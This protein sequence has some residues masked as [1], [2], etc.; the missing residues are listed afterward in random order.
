M[1]LIDK[2]YYVKKYRPP[3]SRF[4]DTLK[5]T[6]PQNINYINTQIKPK[7]EKYTKK[8]SGILCF[9]QKNFQ[10]EV[11]LIKKRFTYEFLDFLLGKY[12]LSNDN[13]LLKLFN[14]MTAQEKLY[15][16]TLDFDTMWYNIWMGRKQ[17]VFKRD[18]RYSQKEMKKYWCNKSRFER[19]F[20]NE[21]STKRIKTLINNSDTKGYL[22]GIPKGRINDKESNL[23]AAIREFEEETNVFKRNYKLLGSYIKDRV[24]VDTTIYDSCYFLAV[25]TKWF[26]PKINLLTT[27]ENI[28]E[29]DEAKWIPINQLS[30]LNLSSNTYK[31]I[32]NAR[33]LI[34]K[35]HGSLSNI[36]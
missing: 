7:Y 2:E 13:D 22:W 23:N 16:M 1:D 30:V 20:A 8:S 29:I 12:K 32:K 9:R 11:L 19:I 36:L 24:E 26:D 15:I 4:V 6:K 18:I 3:A 14:G 33:K 25:A 5:D 17:N 34:K 28:L 31:I 21:Q 10:I 27:K 35:R